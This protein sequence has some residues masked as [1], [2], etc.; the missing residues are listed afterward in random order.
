MYTSSYII[1]YSF[2][3][4]FSSFLL[5]VT[6]QGLYPNVSSH[7]GAVMPKVL[8]FC[9]YSC[10]LSFSSFPLSFTEQELYPNGSSH[11]EAVMPKVL[12]Y[13]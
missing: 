12:G 3:L 6:E 5:S 4:S 13:C 2:Y 10:Y 7:L 11:L 8:E 9:Y 1:I